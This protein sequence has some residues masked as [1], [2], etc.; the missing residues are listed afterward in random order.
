MYFIWRCYGY[1][2]SK[3][4]L[5]AFFI[6]WSLAN[7]VDSWPHLGH[8]ISKAGDSR[9]DIMNSRNSLCA[10]IDYFYVIFKVRVLSLKWR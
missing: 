10:Q 4:N 6:E 1:S 8:I 2:S 5:P 3:Q 7:Y 9:L